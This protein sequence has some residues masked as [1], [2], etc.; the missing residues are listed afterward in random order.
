MTN[1]L[2][3]IEASEKQINALLADYKE[4]KG[5]DPYTLNK[6]LEIR[7]GINTAIDKHNY[8]K[9]VIE[10]IKA[11]IKHVK[12]DASNR[13][14]EFENYIK[15]NNHEIENYQKLINEKTPL[16]NAEFIDFDYSSVNAVIK[17]S[18]NEYKNVIFGNQQLIKFNKEK[19]AELK[20]YELNTLKELNSLKEQLEKELKD[21]EPLLIPNTSEASESTKQA[22]GI[23]LEAQIKFKGYDGKSIPVADIARLFLAMEKA[24]LTRENIKEKNLQ[25]IVGDA[26]ASTLKVAYKRVK[27]E[28]FNT[29]SSYIA[30]YIIKLIEIS[31]NN[32][33]NPDPTSV[34]IR[35]LKRIKDYVL[36]SLNKKYI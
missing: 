2:Q 20:G 11:D 15:K 12:N 35:Q 27:T 7:I 36:E 3:L 14:K 16:P 25:N 8:T 18:I 23:P 31:F 30:D 4:H 22:K 6:S 24:N 1:T 5:V 10:L 26:N 28:H 32:N 19:I 29:E 21:Y 34:R 33:I 13:I 9:A 17:H